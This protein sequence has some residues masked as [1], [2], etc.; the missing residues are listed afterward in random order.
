MLM[1]IIC[2]QP[3]KAW[4]LY[5]SAGYSEDPGIVWSREPSELY[6]YIYI[7]LE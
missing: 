5:T 1:H 3:A 2:N 4:Y 6:I 7:Y